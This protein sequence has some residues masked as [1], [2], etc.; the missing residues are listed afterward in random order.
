MY[1]FDGAAQGRLDQFLGIIGNVLGEDRRKASFAH[2]AFGLLG[3]GERKS[4]EPIAARACPDPAKLDAMHQRLLH[5]LNES[6]WSD[7]EVRLEAT[8]YAVAAMTAS[9]PVDAW[10][11][12]DTGFLK[13]GKHSVGVQRQ[14]TGSAGKITNCQIGVSLGIAT[15]SDHIAVDFE[16]YLP[17]SWAD[18]A[19]R[20]R[21]AGV[22]ADV[23]FKTKHELAL[24]MVRRAVAADLPRGVVLADSAYGNSFAF[25]EELTRLG[26][27][28]AV[29]IDSS[30]KLFVVGDADQSNAESISARDLGLR[31]AYRP[32]AYRRITWRDGTRGPL[33]AR[34]VFRRV[35]P[36]KDNGA[37]PAWRQ[38]VWFVAEWRDDEVQP[39]H[40]YLVT[41][42]TDWSRR[43]LVRL[44]KERWRVERTYED[45]KG[46]LGL[47]HFEGRRFAGWHHHVSVALCCYAFVVAE[48]VR[49]FP[50][51][52]VLEEDHDAFSLAA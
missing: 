20:R 28:Y 12:D 7:E 43:R 13:Q 51:G 26:L 31:L 6:R 37:D 22:P 17:R 41:L 52:A 8:R 40:Y 39:S 44:L 10:L 2:Y 35:V 24:E 3:D 33:G 42:P 50:P 19:A 15:A 36:A 9:A 5:F 18:D 49:R 21:E 4:V 30:T 32:K 34:F 16:L 38:V 46:E 27:D 1:K 14:Y 29:A 25:R 48:R 23:R 45:L 47:D 11:I